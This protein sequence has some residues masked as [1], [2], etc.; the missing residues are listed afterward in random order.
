MITNTNKRI[1]IINYFLAFFII[2]PPLI[3]AQSRVGSGIRKS[4]KK[5][6]GTDFENVKICKWKDDAKT[7]ANLSFDDNNI[8]ARAIS[9]LL[10]QY[11]FKGTF[12]FNSL[13]MNVDSIK[14][15]L[16]NGHEIGNHT[17]SH[18]RFTD[19]LDSVSIDFEIRESKE[20]IENTF[21]IKCVSLA[22]PG[23]VKSKMGTKISYMYHLFIRNYSA[24]ADIEEIRLPYSLLTM[25]QLE[26]NLADCLNRGVF[27]KL[28]GHGM[29]GDGYRPSDKLFIKQTLDYLKPYSD[30]GSLWVT[31][32]KEG[33]QY[34]NLYHEIELEKKLQ[35]DTLS[36]T[37]LNYNKEKYKDL[38]SSLISIEIPLKISKD[39]SCLSNN[40][41]VKK[42][43][44][45]FVLTFDLK[46][47]TVISIKLNNTDL[48][49]DT[50]KNDSLKIFP[51]PTKDLLNLKCV[52]DIT[53]VVI[54]SL[55]GQIELY[56]SNVSCLDISHLSSGI[57]LVKVTTLY[58]NSEIVYR[59]KFLKN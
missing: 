2:L 26:M 45:K 5:S 10:D 8:S 1:Y 47:D 54:Y 42:L 30:N 35:K 21:G 57:H 51:N 36:L 24:Y 11:H 14:E 7:C 13:Y 9:R 4:S 44:D 18:Q 41:A 19:D 53:S 12:F 39:I 49:Y 46:K 20:M 27:L 50:K 15:I 58:N 22:E 23:H 38:D 55:G 25:E 40:V 59:D 37:F 48:L 28:S 34:E 6:S 43:S 31:T 33:E 32:L 52:G 16:H 3:H 29:A 17:F 56:K